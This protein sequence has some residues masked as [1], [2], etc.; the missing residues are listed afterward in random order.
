VN[1]ILVAEIDLNALKELLRII[2]FSKIWRVA[3]KKIDIV[4]CGHDLLKV[5]VDY[6]N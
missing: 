3:F 6:P 2:L 5:T 1:A 4:S